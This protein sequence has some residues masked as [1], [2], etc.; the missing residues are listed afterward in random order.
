M[1]EE[2]F[3][4]G[5]NSNRML[6]VTPFNGNLKVHIRQ[7]YVD[8]NGEMKAGRIGITLSLEEFNKLVTLIPQVQEGI[9]RFEIRDTGISSSPF[10]VSQAEAIFPDLDS[11]FLPSPPSQEPISTIRDD[12]LL[13]SQP[14]FALPP[15]PLTDVPPLVNP[16]LEKIL[17]D[18]SPKDKEKVESSPVVFEIKDSEFEGVPGI[19]EH[20]SKRQK[21]K[22][23]HSQKKSN[24][25]N[26]K[27]KSPAT[28][29]KNGTTSNEDILKPTEINLVNSGKRKMI[30]DCDHKCSKAVGF[31]Y[32]GVVLHCAECEV[33]KKKIKTEN[34]RPSGIFVGYWEN[35]SGRK[36]EEKKERKTL[37]KEECID[38]VTS[39]ESM[40]EV[41]RKLW[42]T[43]YDKLSEKIMDV[44]REKCTGCQSDETNQPG[45]ELCMMSSSEEQVNLCFEEAY[46][47]V[48]WNDVMECWY[49]K[50]LEMP[51]NLNPETLAIFRET[52]NPKECSYKNRLKKWLIESPTVEL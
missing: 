15:S 27:D 7:F 21:R 51:V 47:R 37:V 48:I 43:H 17:S 50:V 41:E 45:H 19:Y 39:V 23:A 49:K 31:S 44:V 11:V 4:L 16:S 52:V 26:V 34:K 3:S 2:R 42:L 25:R 38:E 9:A 32:P 36:E 18:L 8:G 13:D 33:E 28:T 46:K 35:P 14:K 12:E 40:K 24:V 6:T 1:L 29:V 20:T 5:E 30:N 10:A 22:T